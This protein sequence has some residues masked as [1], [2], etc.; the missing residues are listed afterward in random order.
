MHRLYQRDANPCPCSKGDHTDDLRLDLLL[1][2]LSMHIHSPNS[3]FE[4]KSTFGF[5]YYSQGKEGGRRDVIPYLDTSSKD[6]MLHGRELYMLDT[7]YWE[8]FW[9]DALSINQGNFLERNHQVNMMGNIFADAAFVL[10]WLGNA[11]MNPS[12]PGMP[13]SNP[14][15]VSVIRY[16]LW[17][18][19]NIRKESGLS[20]KL[21]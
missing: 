3:A 19:T 13:L 15:M 7:R 9:I 2:D 5:G 4:Q 12:S 8:F 1:L 21:C 16:K 20:K 6:W 18:I 17:A 14:R 11:G 10:A